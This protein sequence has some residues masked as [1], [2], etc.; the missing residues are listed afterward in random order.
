MRSQTDLEAHDRVEE[1]RY[2][3][4]DQRQIQEEHQRQPSLSALREQPAALQRLERPEALQDRHRER[5]RDL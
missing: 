3:G 1:P 4:C 2:S 5:R